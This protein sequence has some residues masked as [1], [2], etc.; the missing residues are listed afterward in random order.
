MCKES[1][2]CTGMQYLLH[3]NALLKN[4]FI[5]VLVL[6]NA[7]VPEFSNN[8]VRVCQFFCLFVCLSVWLS[9]CPHDYAG[10]SA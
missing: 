4:R 3:K 5:K 6:Y 7:G 1:Y 9:T 8:K 10:H 2:A